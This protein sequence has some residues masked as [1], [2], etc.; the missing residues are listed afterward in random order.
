MGY[1]RILLWQEWPSS[2]HTQQMSTTVL[3]LEDDDFIRMALV[4]TLTLHDIEV[5]ASCKTAAEAVAEG[6]KHHPQAALLDL[7]LGKGPTGLDVARALRRNNPAVGIIFL[8]SFED[9]RLIASPGQEPPA[10]SQYLIKRLVSSVETIRE[11]IDKSLASRKR[12]PL[13]PDPSSAF[14]RLTH[15]QVETLRLVAE[16]F[17]NQEIARKRSITEKSVEQ[18]IGRIAKRLGIERDLDRN[19]R[20]SIARAF[21]RQSGAWSDDSD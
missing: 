12:H 19:V 13:D 4:G 10:G 9:P 15:S 6:D 20:V 8:T 11:A 2:R 21:F 3:V 18:Q 5:V 14:G 17:S 16:G 7:D 1:P